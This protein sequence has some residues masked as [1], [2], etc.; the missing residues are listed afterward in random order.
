MRRASLL[1]GRPNP[2]I[3]MQIW[4]S[5]GWA[6]AARRRR[7]G[8]GFSKRNPSWNGVSRLM[9]LLPKAL[10]MRNAVCSAVGIPEQ[11]QT[12]AVP[13]RGHDGSRGSSLDWMELGTRTSQPIPRR[14]WNERMRTGS[15][16]TGATGK[17]AFRSR[18]MISTAQ[19]HLSN[20]GGDVPDEAPP[21]PQRPA[22]AG[23]R[24]FSRRS[25]P[26]AQ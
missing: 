17:A 1:S 22:L 12:L 24:C 2:G 6:A 10:Q 14:T 26:V 20:P 21:L 15:Y 7:V 5:V 9:G 19:I 25:L 18:A 4:V 11:P 23:G 16:H 3:R 8:R 13:S